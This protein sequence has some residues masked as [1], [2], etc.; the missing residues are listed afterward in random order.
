MS[1]ECWNVERGGNL[2]K[3]AKRPVQEGDETITAFR[4]GVVTLRSNVRTD[5]FTNS[6]VDA[7]YQ[8]ISKDD[9][10]IHGMDSFAG[11]I[12]V[13]DADGKGSPILIPLVPLRDD[14]NPHFYAYYMRN[15]AG[16]GYISS[17]GQGIRIRSVDFKYNKFK[18]IKMPHP[19]I[20][21]Q[22]EIVAK[23]DDKTQNIDSQIALLK[24]KLTRLDEYKTALIHNAVTKGL[25]ANGCRIL[26]GTPASEIKWKPSGVEWIGDIPIEANS[27]N[28]KPFMFS[29]KEVN[30]RMERTNV[31]S[32]TLNGVITKDLSDMG[33]LLPSDYS[34]YQYFNKGDLVFKLIDL[35][36]QKTSRVGKV[37]EDGIMSPAY[38]RMIPTGDICLDYQYFWFYSL[39][40]SMIFNGLAGNG[41]RNAI[42]KE[43]LIRLPFVEWNKD[44]ASAIAN[45]LSRK[46][47]LIDKLSSVV[48]NKIG[49]LVEYKKSLI[50]EVMSGA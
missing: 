30:K 7:G 34:T 5:G 41:V 8:H 44:E 17:L 16:K 15:L 3:Q 47:E 1:N 33:G 22:N 21:I 40:R 37:H 28:G 11:A 42:G 43:D 48:E 9:L 12:G 39:Y 49:K 24:T 45:F 27:T 23:L 4:N 25:D 2:F 38:I 6:I 32:L 29:K 20:A 26:D 18:A 35:E 31:L 13:S 50:N 10:V 46:V 19:P 14:A 36:N